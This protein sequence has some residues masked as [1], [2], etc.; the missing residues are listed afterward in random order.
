MSREGEIRD[1]THHA[2]AAHWRAN[3]LEPREDLGCLHILVH[4]CCMRVDFKNRFLYERY[5][6]P[7]FDQMAQ[8]EEEDGG[9][10]GKRSIFS[11][12]VST[13]GGQVR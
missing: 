9:M 2:G 11:Y 3:T 7:Y 6:Q 4:I 13:G 12:L 1:M 5:L 10:R 8:T